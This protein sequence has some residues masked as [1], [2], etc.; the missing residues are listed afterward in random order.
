MISWKRLAMISFFWRLD[1][2]GVFFFTGLGKRVIAGE[3]LF[4]SFIGGLFG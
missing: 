4:L 1:K 2:R 3:S